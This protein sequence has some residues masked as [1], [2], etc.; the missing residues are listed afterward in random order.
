MSASRVAIPSSPEVLLRQIFPD[1]LKEEGEPSSVAFYPWRDVD[2][3]CLSVDR[4]SMVSAKDA[5][6]LFTAPPPH[7]FGRNAVEVWGVSVAEAYAQQLP[8]WEDPVAAANGYPA[9]PHHALIDFNPLPRK[10]WSKVGKFLKSAA[11][12]RKRLYP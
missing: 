8:V 11:I 6:A 2:D 1:W 12:D 5:L 9:N 3:G 7:G 4:G 10:R